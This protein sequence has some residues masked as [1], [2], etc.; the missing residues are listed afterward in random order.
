[1]ARQATGIPL[2]AT[3]PRRL[4]PLVLDDLASKMI[5]LAAPRQTGKTT[6]AKDLLEAH[7]P[8][9]AAASYF[10]SVQ[11]AFYRM[12]PSFRE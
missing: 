4:A 6:F 3:L 11:V 10:V 5:F 7:V 9:A 8:E 12:P 2:G 1:M